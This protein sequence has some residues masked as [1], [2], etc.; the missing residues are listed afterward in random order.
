MSNK[1]LGK[2]LVEGGRITQLQLAEAL[3]IQK[4]ERGR[5]GEILV[6]LGFA[7]KRQIRLVIREFKKRIP[8]GEY[9][10][11]AGVITPEDLDFALAQCNGSRE[12][13]GQILVK[14]EI[15]S[16][17]QLAKYLSDQLDMPYIE[18]YQRLVDISLFNRLPRVFIR[19]NLILPLYKNNGIVTIAV[20]GLPDETIA[21]QLAAVFGDEFDLAISTPSRIQETINALIAHR[22]MPEQ[23]LVLDAASAAESVNRIDLTETQFDQSNSEFRA[24][25]WMNYIINEAIRDRASDIHLESMPE[26]VRIRFRVNGL[27]A[28]KIDLPLDVRAGVFR[29]IKALAGMK[30]A[31][32]FRDQEGRLLGQTETTNIDLRVS[33]FV[34]IHGESINMRV[35]SQESGVMPLND[36][37]LTPNTY[38]ILQHALRQSSGLVIFC[39]PPGSGKTTSMFAAIN[40]INERHLKVVTIEDP[41]EYH[42]PGVVQ[43]QMSSHRDATLA[44]IIESAVHQDPDVIV[45]G[46]IGHDEETRVV[47]RAALTGYKMFFTF[48]ANDVLGA[49][50]RL[51]GDH[52]STLMRSSTPL[53]IVCQRLVRQICPE[54]KTHISP[55][56]RLVAQLPI[57][58]FDAEKYDFCHG[59]GCA[60]CHNSGYHG[61]TGI[62]EALTVTDAMRRA[63]LS[64]ASSQDFIRLARESAPFLSIG[65]VGALKAIR[66]LTTVE[67][68]LRVAPMT[69]NFRADGELLSF[70]E[71]EHI[72]ESAGIVD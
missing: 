57:R 56:P 1:P 37:G 52:L 72:S 23:N 41:V 35:F 38:A 64:G 19:H 61:R 71:I 8:L 45:V 40:K 6:T 5:I 29:R 28:H 53:T 33:S 55:E 49:L 13:L 21:S 15:I 48:H 24:V 17:E 66:Q 70:P 36:V 42:L 67:E 30:F 47:L 12:P 39:G 31:D 11:E 50:L 62:I 46:E 60:S 32:S 18:P 25:E 7:T 20:P 68:V 27:M 4:E 26:C 2:I 34:G 44:E 43:T 58:D 9:L 59:V 65:E 22:P 54:C 51:G 14:A 3:Q 10:L 63:Y 69:S 16:E